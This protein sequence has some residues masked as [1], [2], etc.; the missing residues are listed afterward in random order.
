MTSGSR[1]IDLSEDIWVCGASTVVRDGNI[2]SAVKGD[3][4]GVR[5]RFGRV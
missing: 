3:L 2:V 4:D 1:C 5:G